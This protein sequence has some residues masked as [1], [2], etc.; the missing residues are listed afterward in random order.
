MQIIIPMAGRGDRFVRA[1]HKQI[2]PLIEVDGKPMIEHVIK[3]FP[4]EHDFLFICANDHL[5]S[6]PLRE[7]LQRLAPRSTI[8]GIEP[9]KLGPVHSALEAKEHIRDNEQVLLSYCDFSLL[10]NFHQFAGY[11]RATG[12]DGCIPSYRGFHPHSLGPNLYG[13]LKTRGDWVQEVKEKACFTGDKMQEYASAGI[14]YFKNGAMLK[15]YFQATVDKDLRANG[16]FFAS[17]PYNLMLEDRLNVRLYEVEHFL[18]WGTPEDLREYQ[19]WSE[20]FAKHSDWKPRLHNQ[21]GVTLMPMAG[22][23]KRFREMGIDIPKPMI[24]IDGEPMV[25]RSLASLPLTDRTVAIFQESVDKS[26]SLRQSLQAP[27]RKLSVV[28]LPGPTEGAV[29]TCLAAEAH[30]AA[31]K[32]L[33]I[34]ACDAALVYDDHRFGALSHDTNVDFIVWTFRDHPHANRNPKQYAWVKT[35]EDGSIEAVQCKLPLTDGD[36]H[37]DPGVTGAFWFRKGHYF[38][39]AAK[40]LLAKDERVNNEYYVDSVVALL[41]KK[42]LRGRILDTSHFVCFG[43]PEDV[44]TYD[45]WSA[46]FRKAAHQEA[47]RSE[48]SLRIA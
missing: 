19:S 29:C 48:L 25:E 35:R 11:V 39:E 13:Y 6:T 24:E 14:Y 9:H 12:C 28:T 1:G 23:G 45:Y 41:A 40:E 2:K 32:P 16:E 18:Q 36:V 8:V 44:R 15:K 27:E 46:Y 20:Y 4:S 30:I 33:I 5:A 34:A 21:S 7:V 17:L 37:D 22:E 47:H 26:S 3:L 43:T 42:G 31:D 10:W 38:L